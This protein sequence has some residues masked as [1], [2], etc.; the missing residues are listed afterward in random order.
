[1]SH[2]GHYCFFFLL[3]W[4]AGHYSIGPSLQ[5]GLHGVV[6]GFN[7]SLGQRHTCLDGRSDLN[8]YSKKTFLALY[9]AA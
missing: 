6:D 9:S 8:Y 1:V 3:K 2:A 5:V 4:D 7:V